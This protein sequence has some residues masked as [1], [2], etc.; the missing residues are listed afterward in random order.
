VGQNV[1]LGPLDSP[2]VVRRHWRRRFD[3]MSAVPIHVLLA[4][5]GLILAALGVWLSVSPSQVVVSQEPAVYTITGIRLEARGGGAYSGE[6][7]ALVERDE[8][9]T[10]RAAAST[11]LNGRAMTGLCAWGKHAGYASCLFTISGRTVTATD[12]RTSY[13]WRRRYDDGEEVDLLV[14]GKGIVLV[15]FAVGLRII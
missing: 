1:P 7:G 11:T 8:G 6:S 15:P 12:T 10:L 13:G 5:A 4:V 14:R 3:R 9:E 2:H